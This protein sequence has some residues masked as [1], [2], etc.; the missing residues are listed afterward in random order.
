MIQLVITQAMNSTPFMRRIIAGFYYK[1]LSP[2]L[3]KTDFIFMNYGYAEP[4]NRDGKILLHKSDEPYRLPI[5]MYHHLASAVEL[6][7]KDVLE[8]SCGRG[9]GASFVSLYHCPR[10]LVGV[11][12]TTE[13]IQYCRQ[14]HHRAGLKFLEG[15][16]EDLKFKDGS[17]DVVLNVEASHLYGNVRKFLAEVHRVL[18]PGGYLLLADMRAANEAAELREQL[19]ES[20]F[21]VC[22]ACDISANVLEAIRQEEPYRLLPMYSILPRPLMWVATHLIGADGS[23]LAYGLK[24]KQKVYLSYILRRV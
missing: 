13:A 11:D 22:R 23:V 1:V 19:E 15:D 2:F 7:G 8:V 10:S 9:G 14:K 21:Q 16:A 3:D 6:A 24:T 12:R 18:R 17:F 20:G 4:G 5:Q